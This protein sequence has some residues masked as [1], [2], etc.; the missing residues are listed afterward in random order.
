M[1]E[2]A[3]TVEQQKFAADNH[4]LVY[5]FLRMRGLD[6]NEFYDVVIFGYLKAVKEYL[7]ASTLSQ[8][9]EFSTIAY[10][11]MNDMLYKHFEKQNRQKRKACTISLEATVYGGGEILSLHEILPSSNP[12]MADLET[13][14]L[15]LELASRVSKREM[16]VILMKTE[17]YGVRDIAKTKKMSMKGVNELLA[18]LRDTVLAICYE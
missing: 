15:M 16:D 3:L 6:E 12:L 4:G 14:L 13:D 2:I 1:N 5:S 17:G 11:K 10:T 8:K 7:A 18:G 9:Y